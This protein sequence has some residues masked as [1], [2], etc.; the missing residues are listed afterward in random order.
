MEIL[1]TILVAVSAFV[2]TNLD[3]LFVLTIFFGSKDFNN[4]SV[5]LGQYIGILLLIIFSLLA[6][7]FKFIIPMSYIALFGIIPLGIGLKNIWNLRKKGFKG[8]PNKKFRDLDTGN[9][10]DSKISRETI[11]KV[12]SVTFFNGGDNIG[13]Y[14]SLF[15]SAGIIQLILTNS[16]FIILVGVWCLISYFMVKNRIIGYK[17][18]RYG[19]IILPFVL[20]LIGFVIL[21]GISP[22]FYSKP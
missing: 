19:H 2:A 21:S 7:F 14:M 13:V 6:Y 15:A 4:T 3:D 16:I 10:I 5:V 8:I 1:L 18:E 9:C 17:L 20:I 11:L 22:I 12:A